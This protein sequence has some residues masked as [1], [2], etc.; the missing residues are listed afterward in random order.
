MLNRFEQTLVEGWED[1]Y[2]KSQL[3]LWILLALKDGSKHMAEI[4]SFIAEATNQ[5]IVADD[6]SMYRALRRFVDTDLLSYTTE[7]NDKGPDRKLY[8]LTDSGQAVLSEFVS[9]NIVD[10]YFKPSVKSL[11]L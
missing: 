2:K 1:I 9:R 7:P 11:L 8:L 3:T 10:I 6:K 4:K 5:T